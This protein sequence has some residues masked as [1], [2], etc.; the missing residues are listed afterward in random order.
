MDKGLIWSS[1]STRALFPFIER[2]FAD[3]AFVL[4]KE[5]RPC[6]RSR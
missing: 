2:I 6:P 5:A 1:A 3:A 4:N